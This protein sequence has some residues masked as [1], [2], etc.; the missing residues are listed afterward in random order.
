[1][2][3]CLRL[4]VHRDDVLLQCNQPGAFQLFVEAVKRTRW[5]AQTLEAHR[6]DGSSGGGC[7]A[8][9]RKRPSAHLEEQAPTTRDPQLPTLLIEA[10]GIL[11]DMHQY[12]R[13]VNWCRRVL[14]PAY[15][16]EDATSKTLAACLSD[17]TGMYQLRTIVFRFSPHTATTTAAAAAA[18]TSMPDSMDWDHDS[19]TTT[20][21]SSP[22]AAS[23]TSG[24]PMS[25][26]G[27][28]LKRFRLS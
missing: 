20:T 23:S 15:H 9:A 13:L 8:R 25:A 22:A 4:E 12:V 27:P 5:T 14:K 7:K 21:A 26:M 28:L 16:V 17:D 2:T 10:Q 3:F 6:P 19:H 1:M 18:S 24:S 11:A